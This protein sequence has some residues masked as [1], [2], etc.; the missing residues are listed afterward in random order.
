MAYKRRK[1]GGDGAALRNLKLRFSR[2][3]LYASALITSF[4]CELG[5]AGSGGCADCDKSE[6]ECVECLREISCMTPLDVVAS[7][8]LKL[9]A[10]SNDAVDEAARKIFKSYDS[11]VGLLADRQQ[12]K[13]LEDLEP[14]AMDDDET[15]GEAR[16]FSRDFRDGLLALFFDVDET[17]AK[18]TRFYGVF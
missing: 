4:S 11:F 2:K 18:L 8:L 13:H 9:G 12:R 14:D 10:G 1:R 6:A 5:I 15:F 16:K 17:L 3:L 7:A